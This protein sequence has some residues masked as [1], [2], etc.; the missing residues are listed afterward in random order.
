MQAPMCTAMFHVVASKIQTTYQ[1]GLNFKL[2]LQLT[3]KVENYE[4]VT[5]SH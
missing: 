2:K 4:K 1:E 3:E 5:H